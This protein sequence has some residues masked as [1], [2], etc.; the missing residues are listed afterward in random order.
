MSDKLCLKIKY[1]KNK[2]FQTK[3]TFDR[4]VLKS[5]D[6][7]CEIIK[8][9]ISIILAGKNAKLKNIILQ[10]PK[11]KQIIIENKE[12]WNFLYNFD[13]INEC[14]TSKNSLRIDYD[15]I[16]ENNLNKENTDKNNFQNIYDYIIK[17]IP[18]N[19]Y[20]KS[21][22]KFLNCQDEIAERFKSF[23]LNELIKSNLDEINNVDFG[24]L[25]N[26]EIFEEKLVIPEYN[27]K[28]KYFLDLFKNELI[29][30]N[31]KINNI[32]NI[33]SEEKI[34]IINNNIIQKTIDTN[35][36]KSSKSQQILDKNIF[37]TVLN[38]KIEENQ[39]Y[40]QD[41]FFKPLNIKDYYSGI[42]IIQDGLLSEIN[43]EIKI[44]L[45]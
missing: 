22:F 31:N 35:D 41:K 12:Q 26:E 19:F 6:S 39:Y 9:D 17:K 1:N 23:F 40:D 10:H 36:Q 43:S 20:L 29:R 4:I 14:V 2:V 18:Y 5:Y 15:I 7:I 28:T 25:V 34:N 38:K 30:L 21:L 32:K 37:T 8:N 16:L 44:N 27:I 13:I 3:T 24:K 33:I 11:I 45:K 42:E